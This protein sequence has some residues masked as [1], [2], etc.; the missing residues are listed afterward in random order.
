MLWTCKP[1][2]S[3][4]LDPSFNGRNRLKVLARELS[5]LAAFQP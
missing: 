1:Q 4:S 2:T 5:D 3:N